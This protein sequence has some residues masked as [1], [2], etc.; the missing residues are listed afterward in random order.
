MTWHQE[1]HSIV[2][3]LK[4]SFSQETKKV[5]RGPPAASHVNPR[6]IREA[7]CDWQQQFLWW[8]VTT[9][10]KLIESIFENLKKNTPDLRW[11]RWILR[12]DNTDAGAIG[13]QE[14][15]QTDVSVHSQHKQKN[16]CTERRGFILKITRNVFPYG[17]PS[18]SWARTRTKGHRGISEQSKLTED[19]LTNNLSTPVARRT[20]VTCLC[21]ATSPWGVNPSLAPQGALTESVCLPRFGCDI[22]NIPAADQDL[23]LFNAL[24]QSQ[25]FWGF[26][27]VSI[28]CLRCTH[29]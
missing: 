5:S 4:W 21:W 27:G 9:G 17:N 23:T 15:S 25:P 22:T 1:V 2:C 24:W 20:E 7:Y 26:G 18:S 8:F 16:I 12:S 29:K 3:D 10:R 28:D 6:S 11:A 13:R 19:G 14:N